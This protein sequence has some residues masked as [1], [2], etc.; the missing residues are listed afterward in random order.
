MEGPNSEQC[1][2]P[3]LLGCRLGTSSLPPRRSPSRD[4]RRPPHSPSVPPARRGNRR[5]LPSTASLSHRHQGGQYGEE[6]E[7]GI[8]GLGG[9]HELS[10]VLPLRCSYQRLW[11]AARRETGQ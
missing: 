2:S 11:R 6:D 7:R 4:E 5:I 10:N 9:E 8:A 3:A 1:Y